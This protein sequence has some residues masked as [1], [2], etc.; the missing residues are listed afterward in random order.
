MEIS[1]K[2]LLDGQQR[3]TTLYGIIRGK[4]PRFYDGTSPPPFLNLYFNVETQDLNSMA[5]SK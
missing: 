1:Q 3:I 2:L 5:R 4:E